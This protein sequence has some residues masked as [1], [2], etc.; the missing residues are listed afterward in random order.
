M[1]PTSDYITTRQAIASNCTFAL[2]SVTRMVAELEG[3]DGA[4]FAQWSSLVVGALECACKA[5]Y[6]RFII[7]GVVLLDSQCKDEKWEYFARVMCNV[8]GG[9]YVELAFLIQPAFLKGYE[10]HQL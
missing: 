7:D 4:N 1:Y 10:V 8:D 5:A 3:K 6:S 9:E 2:N